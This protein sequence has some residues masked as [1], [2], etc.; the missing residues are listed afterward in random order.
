MYRLPGD[1]VCNFSKLLSGSASVVKPFLLSKG[2]HKMVVLFHG[3]SF[4]VGVPF[5]G[6]FCRK[7]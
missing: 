1:G 3:C 2:D 6:C 4:V 7:K 5:N